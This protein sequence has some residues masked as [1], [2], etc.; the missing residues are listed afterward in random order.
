MS[1]CNIVPAA[2]D[3]LKEIG[4]YISLDNV[5]AAE[6]WV[7]RLFAEIEFLAESPGLGHSRKELG[8]PSILF[9]RVEA[10]L[11]L[12][13]VLQDGIEVVAVTQG[14]RDLPRLLRE[15]DL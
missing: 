15:R 9:W 13:R 14:S 5:G 10:Y 4:E 8:S 7:N 12:Y 1:Q 2:L 3:D 11:I 6:R